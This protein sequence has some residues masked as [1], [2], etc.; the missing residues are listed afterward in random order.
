M[1][2]FITKNKIEG[3][4][5]IIGHQRFFEFLTAKT[6]EEDTPKGYV[7]LSNCEKLTWNFL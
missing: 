7:S 3:N 5:Y 4:V 2:N 6:F 1:K